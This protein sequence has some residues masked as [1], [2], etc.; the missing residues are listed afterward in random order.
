MRK[1][2]NIQILVAVFL[3]LWASQVFSQVPPA[4]GCGSGPLLIEVRDSLVFMDVR[5]APLNRVLT[6][7][8]EQ[9]HIELSLDSGVTGMVSERMEGVAIEDA[10]QRL[11][12]SRAL[13]FS[14]VPETDSYKI[15]GIGAYQSGDKARLNETVSSD[16][17]AME[18]V[19]P[20]SAPDCNVI[21]GGRSN[22]VISPSLIV[23]LFTF[24]PSGL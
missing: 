12:I 4:K 15:V 9:A 2:K 13:I 5:D 17:P 10:L 8:A 3:L 7:L 11:C 1:M 22:S 18:N 14:H 6:I 21:A 19:A 24:P 16:V 23:T 20:G